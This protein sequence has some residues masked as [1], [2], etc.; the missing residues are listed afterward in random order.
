MKTPTAINKPP[1]PERGCYLC[2]V[3]LRENT[4]GK[5][6]NPP[7]DSAAE[8]HVPP[9][10]LFLKP[11]PNNLIKVPCCWKCNNGHSAFDE[12]LRLVAA[13]SFGCNEA[14]KRIASEKVLPNT[15]A[16]GRHLKFGM[17]F[18]AAMTPLAGNTDL[19]RVEIPAQDFIEGS[20]RMVKGLL[21]TF[22]PGFDY[23][24]SEF[25]AEALPPSPTSQHLSFV[26]VLKRGELLERGNGVFQCWR[27]VDEARLRG[28]WLLV[29]YGSFSF[30]V[31][32]EHNYRSGV[33][34]RSAQELAS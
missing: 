4:A 33:P 13:A 16:G 19:F 20:I 34:D 1:N 30:I 5:G 28:D 24:R 29:F 26:R 22:H 25:L 14:G 11:L 32:H 8:D 6:E 9:E 27:H 10:G 21:Y 12:K 18:L 3:R 31:S 7:P 15:I 23:M 17:S 2:G